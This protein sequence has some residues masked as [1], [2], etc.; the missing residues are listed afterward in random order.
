MKH[1][2][3]EDELGKT[4]KRREDAEKRKNA[5]AAAEE[6]AA[7][8]V[9]FAVAYL[10]AVGFG[11]YADEVLLRPKTPDFE[12]EARLQAE[13]D[14]RQIENLPGQETPDFEEEARLQAEEDARQI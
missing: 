11:H 3:M 8:K 10:R 2:R 4:Q 1:R 12:E 13:E 14:A 6:A 7:D 9:N 5:S